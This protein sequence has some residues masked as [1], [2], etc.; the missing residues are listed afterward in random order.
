[1]RVASAKQRADLGRKLGSVRRYLGFA[2]AE[3]AARLG[4]SRGSLRR[5]ERG[6]RAPSAA[7]LEGLARLYAVDPGRFEPDRPA[8]DL[9]S[10]SPAL[11]ARDRAELRRFA[12]YLRARRSRA[13]R[14]VSK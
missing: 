2:R 10:L 7:E 4:V 6:R 14:P 9:E 11:C 5:I 8:P 1:M 13:V 3:V 12:G